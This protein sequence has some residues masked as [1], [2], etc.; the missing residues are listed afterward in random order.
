MNDTLNYGRPKRIASVSVDR[1]DGTNRTIIYERIDQQ[2]VNVV[3]IGEHGDRRE[4]IVR[5]SPAEFTY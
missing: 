1:S 4:T 5:I 3:S 2:H